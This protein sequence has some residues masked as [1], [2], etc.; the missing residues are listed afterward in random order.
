MADKALLVGINE[1]P[2]SPL[3]G[4]INDV[5]DAARFQSDH[6]GFDPKAI[7]MLTDARATTKM[8][9]DRLNWLVEGL[10]AG[11]RILF[12]FSGHGVQIA[13]RNPK[14]EV[15]GLDEALA[16]V[17]FDWTDGHMIRDKDLH[18]IFSV[19][20]EGVQAVMVS[21]SCH[22]GDL[23]KNADGLGGRRAKRIVP[24][25]DIAWRLEAAQRSGF[26]TKSLAE[27][28][29]PHIALISGCRADQ[30]SAD[31]RFEGRPNGALSYFL[32]QELSKPG[33]T[34]TPLNVLIPKVVETLRQNSYD[35]VP[36]LEGP[37]ALVTGTFF[38][39]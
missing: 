14:G 13:T 27:R 33:G 25:A 34:T 18:R 31:A 10:V 26:K 32:L 12:W 9:L 17:D 5:M 22:S 38:H 28:A 35:Q 39:K 21:D 15:D 36:Q 29:F 2:G 20:P 37:D 23:T 19:I 30:T 16:P 24:P 6:C 3:S 11:D 8:I 7:R 1:Y 4:C